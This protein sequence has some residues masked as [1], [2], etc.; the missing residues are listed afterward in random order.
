MRRLIE[1]V[2]ALDERPGLEQTDAMLAELRQMPRDDFV[3]EMID[4]LLDYRAL[5]GESDQL[6]R[7]GG[8]SPQERDGE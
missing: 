6:H 5:L 2:N 8:P 4:A 3:S 1:M 7:P